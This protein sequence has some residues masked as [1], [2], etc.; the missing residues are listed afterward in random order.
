MAGFISGPVLKADPDA[1]P[2]SDENRALG[3]MSKIYLHNRTGAC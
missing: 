3:L 1:D 2:D